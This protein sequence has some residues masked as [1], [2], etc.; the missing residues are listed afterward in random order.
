MEGTLPELAEI[1]PMVKR[2]WAH[3]KRLETRRIINEQLLNDY[4]VLI[5]W[6]KEQ[7][8]ELAESE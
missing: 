3:E 6:P 7:S 5:E 8:A 2:E 4:E 1:K